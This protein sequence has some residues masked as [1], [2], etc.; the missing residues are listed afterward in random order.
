MFFFQ[1]H[2]K[3]KKLLPCFLP[4]HHLICWAFAV[5]FKD[6]HFHF[7]FSGFLTKSQYNNSVEIDRVH[8]HVLQD[9]VSALPTIIFLPFSYISM[10]CTL[11]SI[12]AS[13]CST[14]V[15]FF[16][17]LIQLPSIERLLFHSSPFRLPCMLTTYHLNVGKLALK[18][19]LYAFCLPLE[20]VAYLLHRH[21]H[22]GGHPQ[23]TPTNSIFFCISLLVFV[24]QLPLLNVDWAS[25][26][27]IKKN[28]RFLKL[29]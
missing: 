9:V 25:F 4:F 8:C 23:N 20:M 2:H 22:Y 5:I 18:P 14:F 3:R 17:F 27:K 24:L 11:I 21:S 7:F 28:Q 29:N 10:S 12:L 6:F 15:V 19:L 13:T 26:F 1:S 16:F